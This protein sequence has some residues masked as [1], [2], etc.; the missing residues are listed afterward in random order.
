MPYFVVYIVIMIIGVLL[1]G[2]RRRGLFGY[3][4]YDDYSYGNAPIDN[5]FSWGANLVNKRNRRIAALK[6]AANYLKPYEK[7]FGSLTL[8]NKFCSLNR[9]KAGDTI[10]CISKEY[11]ENGKCMMLSAKHFSPMDVDEYFDLMCEMF[12]YGTKY[13]DIYNS[14]RA[15]ALITETVYSSKP[16]ESQSQVNQGTPKSQVAKKYEE[17]SSSVKKE[18][19]KLNKDIEKFVK[20]TDGLVDVNNASEAELTALSGINVVVAKKIINYRD[21][22][23]PF[24]SIDD[25]IEVMG[26]KPHFAKR[27]REE[28]CVNKV[29]MK[30]VKK[31]KAE[32]IIDL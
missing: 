5:I 13:I 24:K 29:N 31:A 3:G 15:N 18:P 1:G 28:I 22:V 32:R 2:P 30:K 9:N 16:V 10:V 12:N 17:A 23:R 11:D 7:I 26:I 27:L 4:R 14:L 8:S 25:F 19:Q 20:L 21:T 6:T